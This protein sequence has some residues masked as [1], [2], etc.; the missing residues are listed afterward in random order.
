MNRMCLYHSVLLCIFVFRP[1]GRR[2]YSID[3]E[4]T[5]MRRGWSNAI[6]MTTT[7]TAHASSFPVP[8]TGNRRAMVKRKK[9]VYSGRGAPRLRKK[10]L[11]LVKKCYVPREIVN[12][13]IPG[14]TWA[15][16][17]MVLVGFFL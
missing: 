11:S 2:A 14:E 1:F 15:F 9:D 6:T 7:T 10:T 4:E 3:A 8:V 12:I 13:V 5:R 16:V 17:V